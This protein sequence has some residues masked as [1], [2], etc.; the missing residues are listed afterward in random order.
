MTGWRCRVLSDSGQDM[1]EYALLASFLAI[2]AIATLQAISPLL[3][4]VFVAIKIA[5]MTVAGATF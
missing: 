1:V 2:V 3:R 4:E 5:L